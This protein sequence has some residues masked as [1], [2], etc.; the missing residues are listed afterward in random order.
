LPDRW[1]AAL[2]HAP[3]IEEVW[4]NYISNAIKYG[5]RSDEGESPC[6]ILG[7]DECADLPI[8]FWV[9]DDGAGLSPEEQTRLFTPFERLHQVRTEGHGLGLS[10][11]RRIVEKLGG[12][13]G[14]ESRV[15]QGSTFWFTLPKGNSL[16]Q[17]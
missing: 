17:N 8:R 6:V 14:V 7:F 9:R 3:W 10:I 2:G 15:G 11:A 4:I 16:V 13:V 12:Q 5:G 1:P